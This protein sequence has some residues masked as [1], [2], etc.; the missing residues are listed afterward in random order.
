MVNFKQKLGASRR[1]VI[2]ALP[3]TAAVPV[4]AAE[5]FWTAEYQ[6]KTASAFSATIITPNWRR[7]IALP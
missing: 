7:L 1:S 5:T 4:Q 6:A 3:L 2:L